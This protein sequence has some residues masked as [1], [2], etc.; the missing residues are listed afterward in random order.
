ME[1]KIVYFGASGFDSTIVL[2]REEESEQLKAAREDPG[3]ELEREIWNS[4][5]CVCK[6]SIYAFKCG[7]YFEVYRYTL[8]SGKWSAFLS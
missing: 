2:E 4:T 6:R 1:N 7:S 5:S 3:F 8:E